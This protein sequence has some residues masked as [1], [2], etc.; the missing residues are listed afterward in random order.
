M[1]RYLGCSLCDFAMELGGG[2]EGRRRGSQRSGR[3]GRPSA[4]DSRGAAEICRWGAANCDAMQHEGERPHPGGQNWRS[5]Q[6]QC[7]G[8]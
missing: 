8:G 6:L 3:H 7:T 1:V 2:M 5:N 4:I